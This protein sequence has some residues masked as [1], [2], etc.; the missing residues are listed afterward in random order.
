MM[1]L[2]ICTDQLVLALAKPEQI[3]SLSALSSDPELSALNEKAAAYPR[4]RGLAEEVFVARPDIVVTGTYTLHNTTTLLR[5]LGIQVEEFDYAQTLETIPADIRRMG[6]LLGHEPEAEVMAA[7]LEAE[8]ARLDATVGNERPTI[9][10]YGQNGVA[11]GS[12]TLGDSLLQTAGFRNLAAERGVVGMAPYPLELLVADR[13]DL[14]LISP[15]YTDAPALADQ[16]AAHPA[17]V[18]LGTARSERVAPRG[19]WSCGGPFTVDALRSLRSLR[20]R[21]IGKDGAGG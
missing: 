6:R 13:P 5:H 4:N 9:V 14:I 10:L 1:S 7:T 2:N 3:A 20:D 12:G 15:P 11:T 21:L 16:I 18:A 8:T 17:V 19:A